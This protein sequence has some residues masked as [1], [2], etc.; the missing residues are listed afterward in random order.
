MELNDQL[1]Y[2]VPQG[3][4]KASG[5]GSATI[6]IDVTNHGVTAFR[7]VG[8]DQSLQPLSN[9]IQHLNLDLQLPPASQA[10]L[11]RRGLLI[12]PNGPTCALRLLSTEGTSGN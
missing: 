3:D 8:G 4:L 2:Q 10:T 1:S 11:V 9:T 5:N 6:E 7:I 12:C